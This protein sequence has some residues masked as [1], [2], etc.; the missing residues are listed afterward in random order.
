MAPGKVQ[1]KKSPRA[2]DGLSPP[3]ED[4]VLEAV[5]TMGFALMTPVQAATI[6]HFLGNKDVVV[7]VCEFPRHE[8][9]ECK[10]LTLKTG[11]HW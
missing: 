4:W 9:C 8:T 6:P 11:C 10:I 1:V 5:S 7:E 2:W 3:L